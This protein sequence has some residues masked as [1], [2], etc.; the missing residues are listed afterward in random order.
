MLCVIFPAQCYLHVA[1]WQAPRGLQH[2]PLPQLLCCA[3]GD[4]CPVLENSERDE[5]Y[6]KDSW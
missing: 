5:G 2:Y 4:E 6:Q 1:H 3:C